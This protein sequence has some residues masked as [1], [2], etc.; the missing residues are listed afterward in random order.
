[1]FPAVCEVL[2][3]RRLFSIPLP[4]IPA[5]DFLVTNY[6]AVGDGATNNTTDIQK[7][8]NAAISA[9]GGTV[10]VPAASAPYECGPITL[11]SKINLQIDSGAT[12]QM[13]AYNTYPGAPYTGSTQNFITFNNDTNCEISGSG[14]IDGQGSPWWTAYN[15][16]HNINRPRLIEIENCNTVFLQ[17]VNL[18]NGPTFHVAFGATSNVTV[19]NITVNAPSTSPN[20][21][22]IDPAGSNYLIENCTISTGD[23][24]IAIKPQNTTCSNITVTGCAFGTGHGLSVGGETND[25]LNGL[26]VTDCTF[27]GTVSG[28]RLKAERGSGGLVQNCSYTD[29]TMTNVQYPININSYYPNTIPPNSD[30]TDTAQAVT[31]SSFTPIWTN[32]TLANITSTT[33]S[34]MSNFNGSQCAILWGLPEEPINGVTFTNVQISAQLGVDLD[35]TRNISFDSQTTFTTASGPDLIGDTATTVPE[36]NVTTL[37]GF[38]DQD[39]GSPSIAGSSLYDPDSH[40]WTN[41]GS[42]AG[43]VGT[44]DQFNFAET[45]MTGDGSVIADVTSAAPGSGVMIRESTSGTAAFAATMLTSGGVDFQFRPSD[46]ATVQSV[47]VNGITAPRYLEIT[48]EGSTFVADYSSN[49]STWTQITPAE[50]INMNTSALDGLAVTSNTNS[51]TSAATFTNV[52]VTLAPVA[53]LSF[54]QQPSSANAGNSITPAITVEA[55]DMYGTPTPNVPVTLAV[56]SGPSSTLGGS[57]TINTTSSGTATFSNIS[58][59]TAGLY[60]LE[61]EDGTIRTISSSFTITSSVNFTGAGDGVNWTNAANWSNG[62]VPNQYEFV[63]IPATA[64]VVLQGPGTY[65]AG[66]LTIQSGGSLDMTDAAL[67][68]DYTG[69]DPIASIASYIQSGFNGGAWNGPGIFSSAVAAA[70]SSGGGGGAYG[71]GYA[72]GADDTDPDLGSAQIE[73]M[74]TLLGDATLTGTVGFGDFQ[75]LAQ[76]FGSAGGWDEGNFNYGGTI[77]FGDYQLLAQNFG[78]TSSLSAG[79]IAPSGSSAAVAAASPPAATASSVQEPSDLPD[80][81]ITLATLNPGDDAR[82]IL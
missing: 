52:G 56:F 22:G 61:A 23:D 76:Y 40:D 25:G 66:A 44:S 30:Y 67:L 38:N 48:R 50:T 21:D 10:E 62:Q 78:Q 68:I 31:T 71:V 45:P 77:S 17:N 16:N 11:G 35:H 12:L 53:T 34:S 32:I 18:T 69:S 5:N 74:P 14:N 36:D 13:L 80:T 63:T 73:I 19:N 65:K 79:E 82:D 24:N 15:A 20:T 28:I 8:I 49:G 37:A 57:L 1:M 72:D 75:I 46:G 39:I 33:S 26:I 3:K 7:C 81:I 9:G 29:L 70:N 47:Q 2:E 51:S 54:V 64:N 4:Q 60:S 59:G 58:L 43:L 27:N 41:K 6:G 55:T 42:G